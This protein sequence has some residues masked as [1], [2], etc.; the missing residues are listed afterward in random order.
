MGDITA[1]EFATDAQADSLDFAHPA[2]TLTVLGARNDTLLHLVFDS[3]A[4]GTWVRRAA[5]G[6]VFRL[7][8]WRADQLT[9]ADSALRKK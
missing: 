3:T 2:R 9:P 4:S 5:G 1:L 6:P 7:D 8:F